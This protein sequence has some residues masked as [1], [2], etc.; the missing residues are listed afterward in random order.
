MPS[1]TLPTSD[2]SPPG[3]D[4]IEAYV[5]A[6]N[7][8]SARVLEKCGFRAVRT[9]EGEF[10]CERLGRVDTVVWRV[11]R[12]GEGVE[13]ELMGQEGQGEGFVPPVQ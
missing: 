12:P 9:L 1:P 7:A 5:V 13:G 8:A 3:F 4:Y 10:E 11:G 6:P 2:P